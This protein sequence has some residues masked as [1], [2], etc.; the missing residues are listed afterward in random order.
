MSEQKWS[1]ADRFVFVMGEIQKIDDG[2]DNDNPHRYPLPQMRQ[3]AEKI[4]MDALKTASEV[5]DTACV[6]KREIN[7]MDARKK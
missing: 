2:V 5:A 1:L 4:L 6:L 7:A 3:T